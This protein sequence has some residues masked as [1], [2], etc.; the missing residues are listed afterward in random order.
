VNFQALKKNPNY[1]FRRRKQF[2]KDSHEKRKEEL[3]KLVSDEEL[4]AMRNKIRD[5]V[6]KK[7]LSL[8]KNT[9][10]QKLKI[11]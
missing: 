7:N 11:I 6:S 2:D 8:I 1:Y 9:Q 4:E 3:F 10:M 5:C